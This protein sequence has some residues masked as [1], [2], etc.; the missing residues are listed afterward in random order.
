MLLLYLSS[1]QEEYPELK[2]AAITTTLNE[3]F[4]S[5]IREWVVT[6]DILEFAV[7]FPYVLQ[8]LLKSSKTAPTTLPFHYFTPDSHYEQSTGFIPF[9]ELPQIPKIPI[10]E[11][12][13]NNR[14]LLSQYRKTYLIGLSIRQQNSKSKAG[15]CL[16]ICSSGK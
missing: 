8:E 4:Y 12:T 11:I 6:P 3:N 9:N 2:Q 15:I 10:V 13:E 1:M 14:Q 7:L 16:C 5:L